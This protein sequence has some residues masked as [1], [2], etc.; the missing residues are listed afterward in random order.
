MPTQ[1]KNLLSETALRL[2]DVLP[3]MSKLSAS[4]PKERAAI[5]ADPKFQKAMQ[6][7]TGKKLPGYEDITT[8]LE[9]RGFDTA[10]ARSYAL[11]ATGNDLRKRAA[12]ADTFSYSSDT[13]RPDPDDNY[14][15]S[16]NMGDVWRKLQREF[17]DWP[18]G[19]LKDAASSVS[20]SMSPEARKVQ[21]RYQELVKE[22]TKEESAHSLAEAAKLLSRKVLYAA[23]KEMLATGTYQFRLPNK[24]QELTNEIFGRQAFI[25][26]P[27][28][29][30]EEKAKG[31]AE[32]KK[33]GFKIEPY[34]ES[35]ASSIRVSY[36]KG[37]HWDESVQGSGHGQ[38]LTEAKS[39]ITKQD[40][41]SKKG[42][43]VA[44][45]AEVTLSWK[46]SSGA[47]QP[48]LTRITDSS[49]NTVAVR[50][51]NLDKYVSGISKAPSIKT[52]EK[53]SDDGVAKSVLG[54]K[55]EPDGWDDDES[56][57]WMLAMG[58]I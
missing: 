56:P 27:W 45:G 19:E 29:D 39:R 17:K 24:Y 1:L 38:R 35:R 14:V 22:Y 48:Q 52:L 37:W 26:F 41:T 7:L 53:W 57:S 42:V 23:L 50:T 34:D 47:E 33:R 11:L 2:S 40:I 36:F 55:V 15:E 25:F 46:S 54:A 4:S 43:T 8:A 31:E 58:L 21:V 18:L 3:K 16:L 51:A 10:T 12:S 44:K 20:P 32:L 49:G 30:V 28:K 5:A 9:R 13:S 6:M